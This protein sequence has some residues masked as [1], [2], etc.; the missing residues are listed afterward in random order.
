MDAER[1]TE[2]LSWALHLQRY[3]D[4]NKAAN[5]A[6]AAERKKLVD[7]LQA[8]PCSASAWAQFLMHEEA[9]LSSVSTRSTTKG[10]PGLR[11]LF[12]CAT[13]LVP[14][15]H[16]QASE[17]YTY[18][19]IGHARHIWYRHQDEGRDVFKA[20]KNRQYPHKGAQVYHEWA[21]L[22][23][24]AGNTS[25]A[26]SVLE[27]GIKDGAEP[28]SMLEAH[29]VRWKS[30]L[31]VGN[32]SGVHG[33]EPMTAIQERKVHFQDV[34]PAA[35][36]ATSLTDGAASFRRAAPST[37]GTQ[38][39]IHDSTY[40]A[41]CSS[42]GG[43]SVSKSST[44][45]LPGDLSLGLSTHQHTGSVPSKNQAS[46][47][48]QPYE[49]DTMNCKSGEET[50][51]Q[52][53]LGASSRGGSG[54]SGNTGTVT[55][56]TGISS[57]LNLAAGAA[58]VA[59]LGSG[60]SNGN[61]MTGSSTKN[62]GLVLRRFGFKSK[63]VRVSNEEKSEASPTVTDV[64]S[65]VMRSSST[66]PVKNSFSTDAPVSQQ[67]AGLGQ[68]AEACT[69]S[70]SAHGGLTVPKPSA[71]SE[72]QVSDD[73]DESATRKRR[74][75]ADAAISP[76]RLVASVVLQ[77]EGMKRRQ[78]PNMAAPFCPPSASGP[79]QAMRSAEAASDA[80]G[81]SS[82]RESNRQR[83]G[84]PDDVRNSSMS[85]LGPRERLSLPEPGPSNTAV[86]VAAVGS[87]RSTGSFSG[88][89]VS[90]PQAR[91]SAQSVAVPQRENTMD[92]CSAGHSS[93]VAGHGGGPLQGRSFSSTPA[94]HA[95]GAG[96]RGASCSDENV[97]PMDVGVGMAP[98][99]PAPTVMDENQAPVS[100]VVKV[101][102]STPSA[103]FGGP[104]ALQHQPSDNR[105]PLR[106]VSYAA[107][108]SSAPPQA[109]VAPAQSQPPMQ[110]PAAPAPQ[111]Q[112]QPQQPAGNWPE[113]LE[114]RQVRPIE[115]ET[116][117]Y[118]H[119]I[120]YQ[121]LDLAGKGGSS[122]V[123]KV[124]GLNRVIYALKRVR[125]QNKDSEAVKGFVEE[126]TLLRQ[127]R[128]KP[129]IIQLIDSQVFYGEGS[130]GVG[131]VY[132]VLEYGDIDLAKLLYSH[133]EARRRANGIVDEREGSSLG[134]AG[135]DGDGSIC[136][137]IDANFIR[138]YWQQMLRAVKCIHD[139]RIVHADLK[140]A[141][142][143]LV[144]GQLKLID[145]G[146]A[147]AIQ[148]DTT[149][150]NRESQVGT[151]NYMS[152]E[153][154][155][156]GSQNPLG[157]PPLKVGRPSD[158]WS[159][160]CILY[161]MIYGRTPFADLAFIPK[162]NA[163]CNPDFQVPMPD[164]GE[165]DA[166][167]C[168]RRCLDR[169]PKTRISLQELLDH[170]FLHPN[171][172]KHQPPQTAEQLSSVPTGSASGMGSLTEE[173]IKAIL[174]LG[175][176]GGGSADLD[177]IAR[178]VMLQL[179]GCDGAVAAD[180][181]TIAASAAAQGVPCVAGVVAAAGPQAAQP[182]PPPQPPPQPIHQKL[183]RGAPPPAPPPPPPPPGPPPAG[184][185]LASS[186]AGQERPPQPI[187]LASTS[188]SA[189]GPGNV[190]DIAAMAAA[191]ATKRAMRL[192]GDSQVKPKPVAPTRP[193]TLASCPP[194]GNNGLLPLAGADLQAAILQRRAQLR[195]VQDQHVQS[196]H[197]QSGSGNAA[198][199]GGALQ[200]GNQAG[201]RQQST[202]AG[203]AEGGLEA[204]LRRG[205]E[206]FHF[207]DSGGDTHGNTE[208]IQAAMK[209][210]R[211]E[212]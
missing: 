62:V 39:K 117:V 155:Q 78:S 205:L 123:Y 1:A 185:R 32:A 61:T 165:P 170:P 4:T 35:F 133:E 120:R 44:T 97:V 3:L 75:P 89:Q 6:S 191:A 2:N 134:N 141:N 181:G 56:P 118:V 211:R 187:S 60:A 144:Q 104:L 52:G 8:N 153:A 33:G 42:G 102:K 189:S 82:A 81:S 159:L 186:A 100:D 83:N 198:E 38:L 93:A 109:S 24:E 154:I 184:V 161:Q 199:G 195:P 209:A 182:P 66:A 99:G 58:A 16:G 68:L 171:R 143:M 150:I 132:M 88:W 176:G 127:L 67:P 114:Q 129:N 116:Y 77:E 166:V 167:D 73:S 5:S 194:P 196:V 140:P 107:T 200:A 125:F 71:S 20:I 152:P 13:E 18:L 47:Q 74:A 188:R 54:N 34:S 157:G 41:T 23:Y 142:F 160:G 40:S 158:V 146:I 49:D 112:L 80:S 30:V 124:L 27:K 46:Y 72:T 212:G 204:V 203:E 202:A 110:P 36:A 178:R 91:L 29:L 177:T 84:C 164:C 136:Q 190:A 12:R 130:S 111:P 183:S 50:R 126:I 148:G 65:P 135:E 21:L 28:R 139:A 137:E 156:G 26:L 179:S 9:M 115:N 79:L 162:M 208:F 145:F 175:V 101:A 173:Q 85:P 103:I 131:F 10:N 201:G 19:W 106:P 180:T 128:G 151:L 63:A 55:M 37:P 193:A 43:S 98:T 172:R 95:R 87:F 108:R 90:Q 192:P 15:Q 96:V 105:E 59:A 7:H 119:G 207:R 22:E 25:K 168:I 113:R 76:A 197:Q 210:A 149:S 94:G 121:K 45:M 206:R 147:K 51:I 31:G 86:N 48:C 11:N 70:V 64:A 14:I 138:L 53:S 17:G 92:A 69:G 57:T 122:K 169:N 163:I 174:Q